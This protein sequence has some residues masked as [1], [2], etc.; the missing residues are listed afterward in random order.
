MNERKE[1][2]MKQ[3][4][5]TVKSPRGIG[6]IIANQLTNQAKE[7]PG[8]TVTLTKGNQTV[9]LGQLLRLLSMHIRQGDRITLRYWTDRVKTESGKTPGE[10]V[11]EKLKDKPVIDRD[12]VKIS[13]M[14]AIGK[15]AQVAQVTIELK[16]K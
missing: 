7:Y 3:F 1:Q 6:A 16:F 5:Y 2:P 14:S 12:S 11:A 10:R 15:D 9:R 8:T 13:D 4:S